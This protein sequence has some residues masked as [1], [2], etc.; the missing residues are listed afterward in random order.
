MLA[1]FEMDNGSMFF[2]DKRK[3]GKIE[4]ID[5]SYN[6]KYFSEIGPD[7]LIEKLNKKEWLEI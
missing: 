3:L 2:C 7:I 6:Q 4:I 1:E 5:F